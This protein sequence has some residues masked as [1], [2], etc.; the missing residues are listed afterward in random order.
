MQNTWRVISTI[1]VCLIAFL[2]SGCATFRSD[3]VGGMDEEMEKNYDLPRVSALFIFSHGK[4][5][6]GLDVIPKLETK[7]QILSGFDDIFF[8]ALSEFSNLGSYSTFTE[9]AADVNDPD[10]RAYKDSLEAS[11]DYVISMRFRRETSFSKLF[12]GSLASTLSLT[13][14]PIP[15]TRSF[16]LET[17]VFERG[18]GL[19][20]EYRHDASVTRWVQTMLVFIYPFHTEKRKVEEIYVD[21][22]HSVFRQIESERILSGD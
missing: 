3:V 2:L 16:S 8:D 7:N 9:Y 5:I 10:R 17:Q 11:H 14:V 13:V 6:K 1:T 4:Q 15:Y 12:L 18:G 19:V 21:I 20:S 22:L